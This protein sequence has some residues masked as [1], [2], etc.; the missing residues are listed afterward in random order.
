MERSMLLFPF[1]HGYSVT[2]SSFNKTA[3]I[4][5]KP[6]KEEPPLLRKG[7]GMPMMG[8]SPMVMDM[9]TTK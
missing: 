5:V 8:S 4:M 2:A 9:L 1:G 6:S 7:S 3:I